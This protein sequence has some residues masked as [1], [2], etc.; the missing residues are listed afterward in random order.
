MNPYQQNIDII[1]DFFKRKLILFF[2]I[3]TILPIF[4]FVFIDA[5]DLINTMGNLGGDLSLS[6]RTTL[7]SAIGSIYFLFIFEVLLAVVFLL[8]F[9]KSD[10]DNGTL[11]APIGIFKVVSVIEFVFTILGSLA[12]V[13]AALP[14][15]LYILAKFSILTSILIVPFMFLSIPAVILLILSQVLFADSVKE[16]VNSIYLERKGTKLFGIMNIIAAVFCIYCAVLWAVFM[17]SYD[18]EM[19]YVFAT[20]PLIIFLVLTAVKYIFGALV[21]LKYTNYIKEFSNSSTSRETKEKTYEEEPSIIFC[22]KCGKALTPDD[23]FCNHCGTPV[24]K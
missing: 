21:G 19:S 7:S 11:K 18:S 22:K 3:F 10:S 14:I 24:D 5:S 17:N 9:V 23:Y 4:S 12:T 13:L 16:S 2:A 8:F 1:K 6:N 15:S 20:D